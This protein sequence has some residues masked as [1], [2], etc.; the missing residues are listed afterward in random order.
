VLLVFWHRQCLVQSWP[1]PSPTTHP[2]L[3]HTAARSLCDSGA[4]CTQRRCTNHTAQAEVVWISADIR[5]QLH[6]LTVQQSTVQDYKVCV[7]WSTSAPN[8]LAE[9]CTPA[10]L[11]TMLFCTAN[12]T[13]PERLRHGLGSNV[14]A[15]TILTYLLT[16]RTH[17]WFTFDGGTGQYLLKI[18]GVLTK[19]HSSKM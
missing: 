6:W 8:Y 3:T 18:R 16:P 4:T 13:L 9:M 7:S 14:Y 10:L 11:Q 19:K 5:D 17:L 1:T 2:K 15:N 12:K